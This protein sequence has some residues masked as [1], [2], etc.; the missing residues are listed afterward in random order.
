LTKL[1]R[2][3]SSIIEEVRQGLAPSMQNTMIEPCSWGTRAGVAIDAAETPHHIFHTLVALVSFSRLTQPILCQFK[4]YKFV[5]DYIVRKSFTTDITF[6]RILQKNKCL[7]TKING[8]CFVSKKTTDN[9]IE[10]RQIRFR[11]CCGNFRN[12]TRVVLDRTQTTL[13]NFYSN[14]FIFQD[15]TCVQY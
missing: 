8:V 6:Y 3:C 4:L 13:C 14:V 11:I 2:A 9:L 7:S 1:Q 12:A 5:N 10:L 15:V